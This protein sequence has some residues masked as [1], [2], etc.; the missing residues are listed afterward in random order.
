MPDWYRPLP[1]QSFVPHMASLD[2]LI[3]PSARSHLAQHPE[4]FV[5]AVMGSISVS[6]PREDHELYCTDLLTGRRQINPE[7]VAW[8]LD[9]DNWSISE[10]SLVQFPLLKGKVR[11]R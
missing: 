2:I 6:W 1:I 4:D 9:I 7:F 10:W 5:D 3:W 11:T 8:C